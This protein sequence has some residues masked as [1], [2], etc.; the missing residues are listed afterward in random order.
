MNPDFNNI[1][2]RKKIYKKAY[3]I[4]INELQKFVGIPQDGVSGM[5]DNIRQAA[6]ELYDQGCVGYSLVNKFPEFMA[7]KPE[8]PTYSPYWWDPY[9]IN[10]RKTIYETHLIN[11]KN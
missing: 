11:I 9:D 7:L 1:E 6:N 5:C 10:I 2:I 4:H 8:L 3:E